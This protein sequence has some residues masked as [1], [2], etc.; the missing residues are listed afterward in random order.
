MGF[1]LKCYYKLGFIGPVLCRA[2]N[3][4]ITY[5]FF[6]SSGFLKTSVQQLGKYLH[7][8]FL[9]AANIFKETHSLGN[10]LDLTKHAPSLHEALCSF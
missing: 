2:E 5:P 10:L 3:G 1:R 7:V 9:E 4:S 6:Q 8:V